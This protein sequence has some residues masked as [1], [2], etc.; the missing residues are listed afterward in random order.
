MS[1]TPKIWVG[2][3]S[4][5]ETVVFDTRCQSTYSSYEVVLWGVSS[6]QFDIYGKEASKA[7]L[8]PVRDTLARNEALGRYTTFVKGLLEANHRAR[9]ETLNV[10]YAGARVSR[11]SRVVGVHC[12]ICK[13]ELDGSIGLECASCGWGLCEC[14]ACGCGRGKNDIGDGTF[15][16][17]SRYA[18]DEGYRRWSALPPRSTDP[19]ELCERVGCVPV[20]ITNGFCGTCDSTITNE[21][22]LGTQRPSYELWHLAQSPHDHVLRK[23]ELALLVAA[24]ERGEVRGIRLK[25]R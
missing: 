7:K 8:R 18:H 1:N 4:D 16:S 5:I 22:C 19:E 3:F 12:Y 24:L 13:N 15:L 25:R 10:K 17:L 9:I 6:G 20:K 14:G 21:W 23:S 2:E 11:R